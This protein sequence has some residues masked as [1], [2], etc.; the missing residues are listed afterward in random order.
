MSDLILV[1]LDFVSDISYYM[2][3]AR[4]RSLAISDGG[5]E[6]KAGEAARYFQQD[7]ECAATRP[8]SPV[9]DDGIVS[10]L[11]PEASIENRSRDFQFKDPNAIPSPSQTHD[12]EGIAERGT[13][14]AVD[15]PQQ[16]DNDNIVHT[17]ELYI[18]QGGADI[19]T[20]DVAADSAHDTTDFQV[21]N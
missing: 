16:M 15:Q 7:A 3:E 10:A 19:L 4:R 9:L 21:C 11:L 12:Q 6:T 20:T 8:T 13:G 5:G 17:N 1:S 14:S 18:T 2:H